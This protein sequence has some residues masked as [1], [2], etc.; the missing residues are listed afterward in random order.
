LA[1]LRAVVFFAV[2]LVAFLAVLR[3]AG[4]TVT[5]FRVDCLGNAT[6]SGGSGPSSSSRRT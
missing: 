1:G 2:R 4:G 5:T 6:R 3:F